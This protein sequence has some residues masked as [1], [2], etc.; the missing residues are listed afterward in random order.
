MPGHCCWSSR[1][2]S[3]GGHRGSRGPHWTGSDLASVGRARAGSVFDQYAF[4]RGGSGWTATK[5]APWNDG[6]EIHAP[7]GTYAAN[8]F[9]LHE[10]IGN[11]LEWCRDPYGRYH[12]PVA[13]GDGFRQAGPDAVPSKV[14]RGGSFRHGVDWA[15]S[16]HRAVVNGD[17]RNEYIGLRPARPTR[18]PCTQP[19]G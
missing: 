15:R 11:V 19:S 16:A 6:A 4:E 3:G 18:G 1:R 8:P 10:T 14:Y 5:L 9:G 7:I 13:P 12:L 17:I 2:R